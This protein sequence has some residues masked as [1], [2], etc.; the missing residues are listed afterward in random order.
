MSEDL[1]C[2]S[3]QHEDARL[4]IPAEVAQL[5]TPFNGSVCSN[6]GDEYTIKNNVVDL[7]GEPS[8]QLSM[9]EYSNHW[10]VTASIYEELWRNRSLSILTGQEFP[11]EKEQQLLLEWL[12]PQA[13]EII[14]DVGCSTGLYARTIAKEV[15]KSINV[16]LDFSR[17]ML[18]EARLKAEADQADIYFLRADA[19]SMPFFADT[20]DALVSGGTLNE[21]SDP[22]KV[23]YECR[24]IIKDTGRFFM[25]H[26]LR[27]ETWYGRLLQDSAEFGGLKFWD[28]EDSNQLF[29]R[30]GFEVLQQEHHGIVCF[31]LLKPDVRM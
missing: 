17:Q 19:R 4:R 7:L 16:G 11:I 23:L 10:T 22:I 20:F 13:G 29:E 27:G 15:P 12:R 31:T 1:V 25:M 21:L 9:A 2:R 18:Q 6:K 8:A 30:A 28:L 26:L 24:R 14:L 5:S 3:P